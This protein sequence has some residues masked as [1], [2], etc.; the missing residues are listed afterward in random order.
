[1]EILSII[2]EFSAFQLSNVEACLRLMEGLILVE[3]VAVCCPDDVR[4]QV[5]L[6]HEQ[7]R[8][9]YHRVLEET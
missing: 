7:L 8:I 4:V 1:M 9:A 5:L 6:C 2:D 3:L